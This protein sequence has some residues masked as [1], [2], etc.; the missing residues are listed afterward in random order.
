MSEDNSSLEV[1]ANTVIC[2]EGDLDNNLYQV[3]SGKLLVCIRKNTMVTPL[4]YLG[5]GDFFGELAFL[6][7]KARSA[8]V[9]ALENTKLTRLSQLYFKKNMPT[10][11]LD[12]F[13]FSTSWIRSL[14][15]V[16]NTRGI[17]KKNVQSIAAL[18][19]D[20]QRQV[21]ELLSQ[22]Q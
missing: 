2:R 14:D 21:Y 12:S 13:R 17:K 6:D 1:K 9:I 11:L 4:A 10:W 19:I 8:D 5:P 20:E 3:V 16:I 18:S 7:S 15:T 22:D